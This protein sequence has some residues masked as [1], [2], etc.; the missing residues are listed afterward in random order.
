[1]VVTV[2]DGGE[3]DDFPDEHDASTSTN[4]TTATRR[5]RPTAGSTH[6]IRHGETNGICEFREPARATAASSKRLFELF[7]QLVVGPFGL[8]EQAGDEAVERLLFRMRE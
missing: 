6:T 8:C 4:M 7:E 5:D 2:V 3:D 1:M